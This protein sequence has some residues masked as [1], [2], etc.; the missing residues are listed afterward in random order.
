M[1]PAVV[2]LILAAALS[3]PPLRAEGPLYPVAPQSPIL[4]LDEERLF[5]ASAFG[6]RLSA[7]IDAEQSAL[8]AENR[9]IEAELTDEER[10]LADRRGTMTPDEFRPLAADFDRRVGEIRQAQ[11]AKLRALVERRDAERRRF[12]AAAI[13]VLAEIIREAGAVAILS[14][15]AI[16]LSFQDI[17]VTDYAIARIDAELG[18]GAVPDGD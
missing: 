7:E 16:V 17:D 13:P 2:A 10:S 14:D 18:D 12:F 9:R 1:R 15:E 4:T 3:A 5:A 11:D 6:R 8:M